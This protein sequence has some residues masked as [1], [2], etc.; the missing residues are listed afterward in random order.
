MIMGGGIGSSSIGVITGEVSPIYPAPTG[1]ADDESSPSPT[2]V[3]V[4]EAQIFPAPGIVIS[5]ESTHSRPGSHSGK[6][7]PVN[8]LNPSQTSPRPAKTSAAQNMLYCSSK[9]M[10]SQYCSGF[11]TEPSGQYLLH[12]HVA[13]PI[14]SSQLDA[15]EV[16]H[17][18]LSPQSSPTLA[19]QLS[20]PHSLGPFLQPTSASMESKSSIHG[21]LL[22]SAIDTRLK[23]SYFW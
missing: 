19:N 18:L 9:E 17:P 14:Q 22:A 15:L 5:P 12:C 1:K 13:T 20:Y 6:G 11:K 4:T 7:S 2:I 8:S 3:I 10:H 23:M 21:L 16:K